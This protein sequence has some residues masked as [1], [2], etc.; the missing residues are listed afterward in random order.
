M[1]LRT[2]QAWLM[3]LGEQ[4]V[5]CLSHIKNVTQVIWTLFALPWGNENYV[6]Q[7][8]RFLVDVFVAPTHETRQRT[9]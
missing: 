6:K 3:S 1:S 7:R 5:A 8:T 9:C 2:R 4:T